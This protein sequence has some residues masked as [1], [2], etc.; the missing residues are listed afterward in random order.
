MFELK[1]TRQREGKESQMHLVTKI[2]WN[3]LCIHFF[4]KKNCFKVIYRR[5]S[6]FSNSCKPFRTG[7]IEYYMMEKDLK[8]QK[9]SDCIDYFGGQLKDQSKNSKRTTYCDYKQLSLTF[10]YQTITEMQPF[11]CKSAKVRYK[12]PV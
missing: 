1:K 8:E 12:T 9:V 2:I 4:L 5:D 10:H 6:I 3:L 11:G 7:T